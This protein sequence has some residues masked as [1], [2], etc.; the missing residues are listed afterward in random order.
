VG[1]AE[2]PGGRPGDP[3]AAPAEDRSGA[4]RELPPRFAKLLLDPQPPPL[5]VFKPAPLVDPPTKAA[6]PKPVRQ[7]TARSIYAVPEA[8]QPVPEKPPGRCSRSR[9]Q[10]APARAAR[11][12]EDLARAARGRRLHQ[13]KDSSRARVLHRRGAGVGSGQGRNSNPVADPSNA[14]RGSGASTTAGL[15]AA[16]P[17]AVLRG[18]PRRWSRGG[19]RRRWMRSGRRRHTAARRQRQCVALDRGNQAG[20]RLQQGAILR[21]LHRALREDPTLRQDRARLKSRQPERSPI[22]KSCRAN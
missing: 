11:D 19:G 15:Q 17:A 21:D 4:P 7:N 10:K 3:G 9:A 8:R 20:L 1:A 6:L 14:T 18:G 22:V 13:L 5:P 2:S 16:I 12:K